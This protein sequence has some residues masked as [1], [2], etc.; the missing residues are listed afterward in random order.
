M[1]VTRELRRSTDM[2]QDVL[3]RTK[4][5]LTL[6]RGQYDLQQAVSDIESEVS[7][8]SHEV[9]MLETE[10]SGIS[11]EVSMLDI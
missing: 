10:V 9:S 1:P 7:T 2:V 6:A 5:D 4:V 3:E 11:D 8:I